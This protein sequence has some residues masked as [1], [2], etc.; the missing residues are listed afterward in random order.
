MLGRLEVKDKMNVRAR[1]VD[2]LFYWNCSPNFGDVLSPYILRRLLGH[3]LHWVAPSD[4]NKFLG[5]GSILTDQTFYSGGNI[6]WGSGTIT[7]KALSPIAYRFPLRRLG[8][9]LH[10]RIKLIFQ[11][12]IILAV[13]GLR[14]RMLLERAGSACPEIFGDPGVLM[15][16]FYKPKVTAER[17]PVGIILHHSQSKYAKSAGLKGFRFITIERESEEEIEAFIDEV[18]SCDK[19]FTTSLHGLIIA[20]AYGVPAQWI[21]LRGSPIHDEASH[22][23]LDYF[24]GVGV[25]PQSPVNID[26]QGEGFSVLL[27][28]D[29]PRITVSAEVGDHLIDVIQPFVSRRK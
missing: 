9:S 24:E 16:R 25:P 7:P 5:V 8:R 11:P 15:P 1:N 12:N 2:A 23:F 14:T 13:R 29:A 22:K 3:D 20:Q 17:A 26:A 10:T 27:N 6:I 19:I 18:C 4:Q 28:F 21:E